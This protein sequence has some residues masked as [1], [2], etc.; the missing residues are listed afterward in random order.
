M[1][2]K[3]KVYDAVV[4]EMVAHGY[5][6]PKYGHIRWVE[7]VKDCYMVNIR[8]TPSNDPA[9]PGNAND[10]DASLTIDKNG[11]LVDFII[12]RNL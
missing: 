1:T 10:M 4:R 5:Q 7:C 6:F 3:T 12:N 8:Y 2:G 11:F 9:S